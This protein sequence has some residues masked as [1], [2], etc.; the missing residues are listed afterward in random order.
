MTE[1]ERQLLNWVSTEYNR[2]SVALS[3]GHG[4]V[5]WLDPGTR[6]SWSEI[7]AKAESLGINRNP[8]NLRQWYHAQNFII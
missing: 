4:R 3:E 7:I 5:D 8:V 6:V 2:R 1:S